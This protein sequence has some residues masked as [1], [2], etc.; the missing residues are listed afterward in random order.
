M[1]RVHD[2]A[3]Q[4]PKWPARGLNFNGLSLKIYS[5]WTSTQYCSIKQVHFVFCSNVCHLLKC[6]VFEDMQ[7][8]LAM[9]LIIDIPM[10]C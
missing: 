2:S 10:N 5:M 8:R 6:C 1:N 9:L 3:A 7:E 4:G